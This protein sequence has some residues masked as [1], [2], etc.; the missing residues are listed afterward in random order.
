MSNNDNLSSPNKSVTGNGNS[1]LD[2][3][4]TNTDAR[5]LSTHNSVVNNSSS[6][7]DNSHHIH[8]NV[9][10]GDLSA[11]GLAP[12]PVKEIKEM[13][14]ADRERLDRAVS[15]IL[16]NRDNIYESFMP[17]LKAIASEFSDND[18]AQYYYYLLLASGSAQNYIIHYKNEEDKSYWLLFWAYTAFKRLGRSNE[19]ESVLSQLSKWQ[20]Q[21]T[22]NLRVIEA[23]GLV[24]DCLKRNG[25]RY[26]LQDAL[27]VT[28]KVV[29]CSEYL[30]P[31]NLLISN[32][33]SRGNF[34]QTGNSEQDFY[35]K[36][37]DFDANKNNQTTS[38]RTEPIVVP[39]IDEPEISDSGGR[40]PESPQ[41][42]GYTQKPND[43]KPDNV[44]QDPDPINNQKGKTNI[45]KFLI[46]GIVIAV[47]FFLGKSCFGSDSDS[48]DKPATVQDEV[49]VP[50]DTVEKTEEKSKTTGKK[51]SG[52]VDAGKIKTG[53]VDTG[54]TKPVNNGTDKSNV[55]KKETQTRV[56]VQE[57]QSK[58]A[59]NQPANT[60]SVSADAIAQKPVASE[61]AANLIASGKRAV[62]S[63]DYATAA[64]YFVKAANMGDN[65]AYF[66]LGMLYTNSNFEGHNVDSAISYMH[67]AAQGGNVEAMYQL[68]ML[69]SG[70]DNSLAKSWLKK[71]AS[72][73]HEKARTALN[74]F[75]N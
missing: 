56:S 26:L 12:K 45:G 18:K 50:V 61:S 59:T 1:Y 21:Y 49:L 27:E 5:D 25:G 44:Y 71:A 2:H 4:T 39:T 73:G 33:I 32:I 58:Q 23:Y 60:V 40:K 7:V 70:R 35:L 55:Q 74:R 28:Q 14:D 66:Q 51:N 54:K 29:Q 43:V 52:N 69:Y 48:K 22:D 24:Y 46:W 53:K 64:N 63:F 16:K 17:K 3:S 75:T 13:T 36:F 15:Q 38:I 37:F 20:D 62:K 57:T 41:I 8:V 67:K 30:K 65:E 6:N 72:R 19:A 47:V 34:E 10:G 68:G 9:Q 42:S 11:L 31:F